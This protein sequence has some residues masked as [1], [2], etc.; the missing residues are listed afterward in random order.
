MQANEEKM[1]L[2]VREEALKEV[3]GKV[4]SYIYHEHNDNWEKDICCYD[5]CFK[6]FSISPMRFN[7]RCN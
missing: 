6:T 7:Y 1:E 5:Y 4:G 3:K 2:R